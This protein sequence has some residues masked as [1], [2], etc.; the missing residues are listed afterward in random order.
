MPLEQRSQGGQWNRPGADSSRRQ[1]PQGQRPE[2]QWN[3]PG[4]DSTRRQWPQ[5][6][7]P[8]GAQGN[9]PARPGSD[10][11]K[12]KENE[13]PHGSVPTNGFSPEEKQSV[14]QNT[15]LPVNEN[16]KNNGDNMNAVQTKDSTRAP[17]F[18]LTSTIPADNSQTKKEIIHI[19][20]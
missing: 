14:G 8:E 11:I 17:A 4:S 6:Q 18:K 20:Q 15:N 2:G 13:A 16:L 12:V 9:R 10:T 19:N 5:G 3:R 1:W 7:R